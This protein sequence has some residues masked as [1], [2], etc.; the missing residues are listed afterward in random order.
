VS[1]ISTKAE[2]VRIIG[3]LVD[4]EVQDNAK[5]SDE[6]EDIERAWFIILN[7]MR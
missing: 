4:K 6:I 1:N 3:K 2:A 7:N 5:K